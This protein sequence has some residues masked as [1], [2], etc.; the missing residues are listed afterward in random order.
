[1]SS[2]D[3]S[4][5]GILRG[6][7]NSSGRTRNRM[8]NIIISKEDI[9]DAGPSASVLVP[10]FN[11]KAASAPKTN[12][13][14]SYQRRNGRGRR[15]SSILDH[16]D[17]D[18]AITNGPAEC[19][20]P[21][22]P[23]TTKA[24]KPRQR[25]T[26]TTETNS[27]VM[28][29]YY[30]A[31]RL[32][33]INT[34][35][36]TDFHRLFTQ[37]YPE[38]GERIT[39]QRLVDQK[40]AILTKNM[41]TDRAVQIIKEEIATELSNQNIQYQ[42]RRNSA[43][44][45][46]RNGTNDMTAP[47]SE[48]QPL[49]ANNNQQVEYPERRTQEEIQERTQRTANINMEEEIDHK[50]QTNI[51]KWKGINPAN[52]TPLPKLIYNKYTPN[53]INMVNSKLGNHTGETNTL[54]DIHLLI[55]AAATT[56]ITLNKQNI[57]DQPIQKRKKSKPKWQI[58]LENKIEKI[59][60]DIG[61]LTQYTKGNH[62][63]QI[64]KHIQ[65]ITHNN[66]ETPIEAL[67]TLKQ[68]LAVYTTRLR[69]Y[70]GSNERKIQNMQFNRSEK[71][72][73]Q[74][75]EKKEEIPIIPPSNDE[76][77]N[78]WENMWSQPKLHNHTATWINTEQERHRNIPQQIDYIITTQELTKTIQKTH[79][80]KAPGIDH[81]HNF[82]YKKFT[83]L[84]T[85]LTEQLNKI[86]LEPH[87]MPQFLTQGN[88]YIKPKNQETQNPANYRPIT[89]LPTLY[90]IITAIITQKIDKHLTQH[91]ILAE[92]QKGCRKNS[93]GC[94]EQVVIDSIVMKQ[95]E[96]QQR[97]LITC[98]IDYKKAF[99]SIPHS[100]L[101][102][103][104]EIYKIDQHIQHF[105]SV[106]MQTWRTTIHLTTNQK[107]IEIDKIK[108]NRGI[109]QGDS[110]SALWF[111]LCLNP[112]SNILKSTTYGFKIK[113]QNTTQHT[114]NH[115]LY[116]DDIKIFAPNKTQ[117]QAL[118]KITEEFTKDT[119]MEF[120]ITK[121]KMLH[122]E[123]GRFYAQETPE[124]LN[125][126][127]IK[128]ME[129]EET[130]KYLGFEQN[131]SINHTS[132]KQQL[133][134]KYKHR[135]TLILKS[136]LNSKNMFRAIN[137]YAIPVLTYSF[138][139]VK[140]SNTDLEELNRL[141]RTKLTEHR[142][143]HPNSCIERITI[144]R[145]EGGRGLLDIQALHNAQ[146]QDLRNYFQ[147]KTTSLH[148]AV[149]K[150][151][152]QY[153]PLNLGQENLQEDTHTFTTEQ[154]KEKWSRKALHG[155]H[156][157][158]I[159]HSNIDKQL[160]YK[161]LT[162]GQL[163]PETE[164]FVLAIQDNVIAT[165]N[166]RKYIINETIDTDVC[167]KC[168]QSRETIEHITGGCKLLAGTDYT[169]RHNTAA[170]IIHQELA[171]KHHLIQTYSPYYRYTPENILENEEYKL[172]WDRTL[173]TD[174]TVV[175]NRPDITLINKREKKTYLIDIAIPNDANI[176]QKEQEKIT[177]YTP[178]AIELKELWKQ[179]TV[180]IVPIIIS[181]TGITTKNFPNQ[182][183]TL[184][185]HTHIHTNIQKAVILKTTTIVRKFLQQ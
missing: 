179:E 35:Y 1:M 167:R 48:T 133:K 149:V 173:H 57:P 111:C 51:I 93:K 23:A 115:L 40:R 184:G 28:R 20:L 181:A 46:D 164:G 15:R 31:T 161:W 53:I 129:P 137:A 166:Y 64:M 10:I 135:L 142:K 49:E 14:S 88:T 36:R 126:E 13:Q 112:L 78:F 21:G 122:I 61:R 41:L 89:C 138:G 9:A 105:L 178:L 158:I 150:A 82:W 130:Y 121:C 114:I 128:N 154:K 176:T 163:F 100:W 183:K 25:L 132:I 77:K 34:G 94:K 168:Q 37:I 145:D 70:K 102:K 47:E 104:L 155:N 12:T 107:R 74:N 68:K 109:F 22:Q 139:I 44:Q 140:W 26:W 159:Q 162:T 3:T 17:D 182:L 73:Y 153:T 6:Y 18:L 33:T 136:R 2:S 19:V 4:S 59:R 27:N 127:V 83:F 81:I 117:M 29:C 180:T 11:R 30:K 62:S 69:R 90:K 98:Y 43:H 123:R 174:K 97:N 65:Y 113:H 67:D 106:T 165:R 85:Y 185:I 152:K 16:N 172:Y 80:W 92:E 119:G 120:G 58:R 66:K 125:N 91:N 169:D 160:S 39:P 54:E 63:K 99:D 56:V 95:T 108:I 7:P 170:K 157:S 8:R 32:E 147:N 60:K 118:L 72:F 38:L 134:R 146:I 87:K 24:G 5:S 151:D 103:I 116:M 76:I 45:Q 96:K 148:Q 156:Y 79:N 131:T 171:R 55:Y 42:R 175:C 101:L 50:I 75:L 141:N 84:H 143:L 86:I 124:T 71:Q 52:R 110:L 144:S 177:K